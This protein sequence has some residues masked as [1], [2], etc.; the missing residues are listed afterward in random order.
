MLNPIM[1]NVANPNVDH[2]SQGRVS[3][4][5]PSY[6]PQQGQGQYEPVSN[7]NA[8]IEEENGNFKSD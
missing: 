7:H 3:T 5:A 1:A 2:P 8:I 6:F 4:T